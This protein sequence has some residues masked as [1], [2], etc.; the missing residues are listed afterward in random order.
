VFVVSA[1]VEMLIILVLGLLLISLS[2][3]VEHLLEV[4]EG[5]EKFRV[6][7]QLTFDEVAR[8]PCAEAGESVRCQANWFGLRK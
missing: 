3:G 5:L 8:R 4:R 6:F 1:E 2:V 7:L